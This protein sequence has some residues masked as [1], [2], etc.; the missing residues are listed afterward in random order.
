MGD[1]ITVP[2]WVDILAFMSQGPYADTIHDFSLELTNVW[3]FNSWTVPVW[4]APAMTS[5]PISQ[6]KESAKCKWSIG[7]MVPNIH[8]QYGILE[9]TI[10][11]LI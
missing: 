2:S 10:K 8:A 3:L 1:R 6:R 9:R 7:K 5:Q 4:P 11:P